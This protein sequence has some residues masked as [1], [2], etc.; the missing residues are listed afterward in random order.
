M[1]PS[2]LILEQQGQGIIASMLN[3]VG[4]SNLTRMLNQAWVMGTEAHVHLSN[5]RVV[6]SNDL[7]EVEKVFAIGGTKKEHVAIQHK[8][9]RK[10]MENAWKMAIERKANG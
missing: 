7:V 2:L 4:M 9:C 6:G 10:I 1:F 3:Q 5:R 8:A